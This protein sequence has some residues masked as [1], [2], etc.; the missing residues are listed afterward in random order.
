MRE[1][2]RP[3]II[4]LAKDL[5]GRRT[6]RVVLEGRPDLPPDIFARL[7]RQGLFFHGVEFIV[8]MVHTIH[9]VREPA[10]VIFGGHDLEFGETLQHA[11]KNDRRQG[12]LHLVDHVHIEQADL[13]KIDL[14]LFTLAGNH[15]E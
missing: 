12:T 3:H 10:R 13:R 14:A 15:V 5:I 1:V 11:A 8:G 2:G 9:E 7:H 6:D 4:V